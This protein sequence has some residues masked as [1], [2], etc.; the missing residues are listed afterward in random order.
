MKQKP[1][2]IV[3]IDEVGNPTVEVIGF[4]GPGCTKLTEALEKVLGA[5][6]KDTKKPEY[7]RREVS[8]VASNRR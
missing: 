6:T 8:N 5:K 4:V 1:E 3:E 2:I 7:N